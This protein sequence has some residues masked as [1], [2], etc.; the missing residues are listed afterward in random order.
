M[1]KEMTEK[2]RLKKGEEKEA[3]YIEPIFCYK[4]RIRLYDVDLLLYE[5]D[6]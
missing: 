2:R 5:N 6:F 3:T 4:V 1:S